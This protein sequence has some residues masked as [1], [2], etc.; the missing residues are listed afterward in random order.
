MSGA[1]VEAFT[2]ELA[3]LL[4][5]G[6]PLGKA[7]HILRREATHAGA[8]RQWSA[9]HDDVVGGKPL[10]EALARWPESFPTVYVAMIRAGETGGFWNWCSIRLRIFAPGKVNCWARSRRRWCTRLCWRVWR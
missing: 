6:V 8:K 9:V 10:A 7:L 4:A 2:R 1:A 3:N 5:A